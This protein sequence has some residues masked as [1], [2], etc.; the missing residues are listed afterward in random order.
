VLLDLAAR[1]SAN[2]QSRERPAS[3]LVSRTGGQHN[4]CASLGPLTVPARFVRGLHFASEVSRRW[5]IALLGTSGGLLQDPASSGSS[6]K[7]PDQAV[8]GRA[9]KPTPRFPGKALV[10]PRL[11]RRPC[12]RASL[13]HPQDRLY[14]HDDIVSEAPGR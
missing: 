10:R 2:H 5:L 7:L 12:P 6:P 11:E 9:V 14:L 4:G 3:T 13:S 8:V 1:E